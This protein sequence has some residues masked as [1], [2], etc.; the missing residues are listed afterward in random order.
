MLLIAIAI[1]WLGYKF[2]EANGWWG[3]MRSG[4]GGSTGGGRSGGGRSGGVT[5]STGGERVSGPRPG[6]SRGSGAVRGVGSRIGRAL[7][8]REAKRIH[9]RDEPPVT[10]GDAWREGMDAG[11]QRGRDRYDEGQQRKLEKELQRQHWEE[12]QARA[13]F[14][15]HGWSPFGLLN[16]HLDRA[17]TCPGCGHGNGANMSRESCPCPREKCLCGTEKADVGPDEEHVFPDYSKP[18]EDDPER[19]GPPED[20]DDEVAAKRRERDE[21]SPPTDGPDQTEPGSPDPAPTGDGTTT[22]PEETDVSAPTAPSPNMSGE[23]INFD[24]ARDVLRGVS[25]DM[26]NL[27]DAATET[28]NRHRGTV[29]ACDSA[30]AG[31]S[32]IDSDPDTIGDFIALREQAMEALEAAEKAQVQAAESASYATTVI[33][34]IDQRHG[35]IEE[36]VRSTKHAAKIEAYKAS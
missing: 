24:S 25:A 6:P 35:A 3:S 7:G 22:D 23:I 27:S 11:K 34:N 20:A 19:W 32:A 12:A 17:L 16:D 1:T 2:G 13:G 33:G 4:G 5:T 29:A 36:A 26:H 21:D 9:D 31:L 15:G 14:P 10:W 8:W 28:V 18:L 30:I